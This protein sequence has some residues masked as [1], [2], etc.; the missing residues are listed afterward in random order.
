[1]FIYVIQAAPVLES[2]PIQQAAKMQATVD[3]MHAA[4][5]EVKNEADAVS[6]IKMW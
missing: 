1:M 3:K 2:E 5:T 6:T 4:A